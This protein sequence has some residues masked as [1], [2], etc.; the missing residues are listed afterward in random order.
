MSDDF[1]RCCAMLGLSNEANCEISTDDYEAAV[2]VVDG[3]V[4][5]SI[6]IV[7]GGDSDVELMFKGRRLVMAQAFGENVAGDEAMSIVLKQVDSLLSM[8]ASWSP[9][10]S[11]SDG[12]ERQVVVIGRMPLVAIGGRHGE[13]VA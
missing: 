5:H 7:S 10:E 12:E 1:T 9:L 13:A 3:P 6:A 8:G 11:A 4:F 2:L